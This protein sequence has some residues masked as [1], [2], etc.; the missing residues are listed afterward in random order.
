[1]GRFSVEGIVERRVKTSLVFLIAIAGL[2]LSA[3]SNIPSG[4]APVETNQGS[5]NRNSNGSGN[6]GD[7]NNSGN[8]RDDSQNPADNPG[9][10]QEPAVS[11]AG[12]LLQPIYLHVLA[13]G[14]LDRIDADGLNHW[15]QKLAS[16]S[17]QSVATGFIDSSEFASVQAT[18]SN[19]AFVTAAYRGFLGRDPEAAGLQH[20]Q[21]VLDGAQADRTAVARAFVASPEFATRCAQLGL[22][23]TGP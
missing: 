22:I 23:S 21:A 16:E 9:G 5:K 2:T 7:S 18:F 19:S 17:C 3:C 10:G 6:S 11:A 8:S 1:M 4:S 20:W 13:R 12:R 14:S 15:T